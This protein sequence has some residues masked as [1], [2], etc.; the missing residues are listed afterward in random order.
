MDYELLQDH[1]IKNNAGYTYDYTTTLLGKGGYGNVYLASDETGKNVAI[2]CCDV[3]DEGIPNILEANIMATIVHPNI[4]PALRIHATDKKLY[5]IQDLAVS[6]LSH[7][8][9]RDKNN[10]KPSIEELR[11]WCY[12][13][14]QGV[15]VLHNENIIHGDI[16]ASN[17]LLFSDG[18]VKLA[19]FTL[20]VKKINVD[21][22]FKHTVCTCT[23]RP[24]ECLMKKDWDESLDIWS[25]GCT[26]YEIAYGE[27]LFPY[28]GSLEKNNKSKSARKRIRERSINAIIDW[29]NRGPN[30]PTS[31]DVIG[32]NQ[33]PLKYIPFVICEDYNDPIMKQFNELFLKM[34]E[35][36]PNKRPTIKEVLNDPFF[37]ECSLLKP[38]TYSKIIRPVNKLPLDEQARVIRYIERYSTN[39]TVQTLALSIYSKCNDLSE[40]KEQLKA[41]AA[42][43]IANK[44]IIGTT[45]KI[46]IQMSVL[47]QIERDIAH[48]LVFRF[49]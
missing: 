26:F 20:A 14:V 6:D 29:S 46:P 4:N 33:Y 31:Y 47:L 7:Y 2:K 25:L 18:S 41:G 30:S 39:T 40:H 23:H 44:I 43:W 9:K 38:N 45:E 27:L 49:I 28:Q 5:I 13:I 19:D 24:L 32:C 34:V 35:V 16:K 3:E 11:K 37:T 17:V 8:T 15:A 36:D 48:N 12:D 42:T 10:Y 1:D 22:K 21:S